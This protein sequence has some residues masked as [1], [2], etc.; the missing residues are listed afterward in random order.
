MRFI[1][2]HNQQNLDRDDK[3]IVQREG[4]KEKYEP[5]IFENV[6]RF[7]IRTND[8]SI[9]YVDG[10]RYQV[11]EIIETANYFTVISQSRTLYSCIKYDE[12]LNFE[13]QF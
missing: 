3:Y 5:E 7:S 9:L 10:D 13:F 2:K 6:R 12:V 8:W 1:R 11:D 4:I